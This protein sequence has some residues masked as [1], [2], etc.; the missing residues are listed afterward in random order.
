MTQQDTTV[1]TQRLVVLQEHEA[2]AE[3]LLVLLNSPFAVSSGYPIP[4]G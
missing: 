3:W 4:I 2:C 1:A